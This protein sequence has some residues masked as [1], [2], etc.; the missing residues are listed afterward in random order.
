MCNTSLERM[1]NEVKVRS[2]G[3]GKMCV[4]KER[5]DDC[6]DPTAN[7]AS[8]LVQ[9][10]TSLFMGLEDALDESCSVDV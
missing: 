1:H 9:F 2:P 4:G 5:G 10:A 3:G 8:F 6:Y 7:R